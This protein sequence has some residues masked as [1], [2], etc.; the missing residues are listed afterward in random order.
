[1]KPDEK[2]VL[3][4]SAYVAYRRFSEQ[5]AGRMRGIYGLESRSSFVGGLVDQIFAHHLKFGP[6]ADTDL[7]ATCR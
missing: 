2:V 6:I 7:T 1:M 4:A 5:A 3:S